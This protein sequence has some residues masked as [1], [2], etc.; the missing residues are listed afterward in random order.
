[1]ADG[2]S[3]QPRQRWQI[4]FSRTDPALRMRQPQLVAEF[5]RAFKEAE[6][7]LAY[8]SAKRPRPRIHLAANPPAGI[9]LRG[10]IVEA[11]FDELVSI[12]RIRAAGERF[13]EGVSL[14]EAREVWHGFPSAAS[15]VRGAEYIVEVS[16]AD[17]T[18]LTERRLRDAVVRLLARK[19]LHG[20]AA[21]GET[22]RRADVGSRDLRPLIEDV[23]VVEVDPAGQ[24]ASLRCVLR[25]EPTGAG[26]PEDVVRALDVPLR[27]ERIV[28]S[29]L[30]FFD[31]PPIAR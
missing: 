16:P 7:P 2:S 22:E 14:I 15:Q 31:T 27:S 5:E 1:M 8:S 13:P 25:L 28:R 17:G 3:R 26:R 21:R 20:K 12:D 29:R 18:P 19:E 4:L 9:E 6:L 11:Y 23:E 24:R 30:L 10:E